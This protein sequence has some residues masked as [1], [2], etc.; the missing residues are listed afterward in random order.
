MT[1]IQTYVFLVSVFIVLAAICCAGCNPTLP[2]P[3]ESDLQAVDTAKFGVM[4]DSLRQGRTLYVQRCGSCH[5]LKYPQDYTAGQWT[6]SVGEMRIR[7]RLSQSDEQNIL[8]YLRFYARKDTLAV[9][10]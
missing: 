4:L 7:A 10:R 8:T 2:V 9:L 3:K 1:I 6:K 5:L